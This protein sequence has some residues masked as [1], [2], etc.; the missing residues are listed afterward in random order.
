[1][2][3]KESVREDCTKCGHYIREISPEQHGCDK[4][5]KPIVPFGND[6]RLDVAVFHSGDSTKHFYFCSW[7]CVFKFVKTVKSDHFFTLPY[8]SINNKIPGRRASDFWKIV[9]KLK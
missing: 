2:L 6:E 9:R 4:C 8:V 5:K 1:M 7:E 3:L